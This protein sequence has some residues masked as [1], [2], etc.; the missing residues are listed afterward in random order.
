MGK[1]LLTPEL[2][3]HA[4]QDMDLQPHPFLFP[5]FCKL[6]AFCENCMCFR[7]NDVVRGKDKWLPIIIFSTAVDHLQ[8][9][10]RVENVLIVKRRG[11]EIFSCVR[12][13]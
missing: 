2:I 9:P 7:F 12:V 8:R 10:G 11:Q 13:S 4:G 1:Y 3:F 6:T 5:F